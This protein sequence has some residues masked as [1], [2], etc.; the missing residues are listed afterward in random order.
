M[1]PRIH[2]RPT[3]YPEPIKTILA[4]YPQGPEGPIR[5]FTTLAHSERALKKIGSAGLLDKG[6]PL[7]MKH[8]EMII[9][10]TSANLG[11]DYEWGIHVQVFSKHVGLTAEQIDDSCN[12]TPTPALWQEEELLLLRVVDSLTTSATIDDELWASVAAKFSVEQ[13]MEILMLAGFYHTIAFLNNAMR[14]EQEDGTPR[15]MYRNSL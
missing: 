1:K 13:I 10:R 14:V 8:R 2:P 4:G 3:P 9:L 6:S 7:S 15:I 11:T 12:Q 5:L